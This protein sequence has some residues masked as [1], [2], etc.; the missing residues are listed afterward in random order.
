MMGC[1]KC[2]GLMVT[3]WVRDLFPEPYVWRCVNCGLL[4]DTTITRNRSLAIQRA[5]AV[6]CP[7][8]D[9]RQQDRHVVHRAR[10]RMASKVCV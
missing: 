6:A 3:E 1:H 10:P 8:S 4:M 2:K 5:R 9:Y 7:P